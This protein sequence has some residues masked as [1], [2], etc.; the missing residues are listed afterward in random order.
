MSLNEQFIFVILM[1][2]IKARCWLELKAQSGVSE[3]LQ[4]N[5]MEEMTTL[6]ASCWGS[7]LGVFLCA[8]RMALV[9]LSC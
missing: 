4:I 1:I 9:V 8:Q 7:F 2:N 3:I 6:L 5:L